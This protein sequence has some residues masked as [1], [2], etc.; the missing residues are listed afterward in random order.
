MILI[1]MGSGG[2][3]DGERRRWGY[4]CVLLNCH[5]ESRVQGWRARGTLP[6]AVECTY[7][8]VH[9]AVADR[10][11]ALDPLSLKQLYAM[12]VIRSVFIN[13]RLI[14]SVRTPPGVVVA[15]MFARVR[16]RSASFPRSLVP[17]A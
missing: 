5:D 4:R 15:L 7:Q 8:M 9:V 12:T 2:V 3:G 1:A 16:A 11:N 10:T 17:S 6:V 13:G 14:P